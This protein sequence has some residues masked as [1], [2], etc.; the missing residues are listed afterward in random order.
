M[1]DSH[2]HLCTE[3]ISENLQRHLQEFTDAGGKNIL[4]V[5]F[6]VQSITDVITQS[7]EYE[8][9][10]PNLLQTGIGIH[11]EYITDEKFN[12]EKGIEFLL[13]NLKT[14][15]KRISAIGECGLDYYHFSFIPTL[16]EDKIEELKEQ[17]RILFRKHIEIAIENNLPL[18]IHTRDS[19]IDNKCSA[20]SLKIV[21][22][23]GKGNARGVFHSYT[24]S[25]DYVK[26]ILDLG[27]YI[28]FNGIIT[29]TKAEAVRDILRNT[30]LNKMLVE[31]D[32]PFLPPHNVRNGNSGDVK[33]G[34]PIDVQ[35]IALMIAKV[36]GIPIEKTWEILNENYQNLFL[37]N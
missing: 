15:K 8:N 34:K 36:K 21:A 6:D 19:K 26:E 20:D 14:H 25:L 24:G 17:Q 7:I 32:A 12:M 23:A 4:N 22:T 2:A 33:Y 35:E 31:T 18:S 3:P 28:G 10:Y 1:Y 5:S 13:E 11:P 16:S 29:Y 30:P 9:S 37:T 27:F